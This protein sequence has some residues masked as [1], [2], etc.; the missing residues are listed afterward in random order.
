MTG[1]Q[2]IERALRDL[3]QTPEGRAYAESVL[4][5]VG[6]DPR[7]RTDHHQPAERRPDMTSTST[8]Y[9]EFLDQL[10]ELLA[11]LR[12]LIDQLDE[13]FPDDGEGGEQ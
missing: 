3:G 13:R 8:T 5:H 2:R 9:R 7:V 12:Q 11:Q 4:A 1:E 6:E 10:Q